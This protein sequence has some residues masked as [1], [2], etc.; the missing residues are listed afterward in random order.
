MSDLHVVLGAG[1]LGTGVATTLVRRGMRVR[2]L[3]RAGSASVPGAESVAADAT[4]PA[5]LGPS[6]TG[7][8]VVYQCAQPPYHRWTKDFPALQ[9]S[10]LQAANQAQA[11]VVIADNLYSYG[12]PEGG[13]ITEASPEATATRKGRLRR[14]LAQQALAAHQ[15]GRLRVAI[16]RPSH[17][18]GPGYDQSG[19]MVFGRALAG[20]SIRMLGRD[21]QPHSFS[22]V[23][24]VAAAMA[25]L[26]TSDLGWG[27]VWIPPV[28][29]AV[30]QAEFAQRVWTAAG[31]PGT[32]RTQLLGR[33]IAAVLGVVS[34]TLR[35]LP[36]MMY[37]FEKPYVVDSSAFETTFGVIATPLDEAIATTLQWYASQRADD[38]HAV[39][40]GQH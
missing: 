17:Y 16:S 40:S 4:D 36:E 29:P 35:E 38:P 21:D 28:Q 31:R 5:G 12:D 20:K 24:D 23:P 30:T 25:T 9:D 27:R 2:I 1:P 14:R 6:F 32:A 10:V 33:R 11:S 15:A 7:A 8:A 37:E 13:I 3:N 39:R 22:Y 26:G 18:F 34:P 19:T